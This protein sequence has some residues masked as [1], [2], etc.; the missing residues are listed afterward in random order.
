MGELPVENDR[1]YPSK[2]ENAF[3][4]TVLMT[5]EKESRLLRTRKN[6]YSELRRRKGQT[7][8]VE[9]SLVI[10]HGAALQLHSIERLRA[11]NL[12]SVR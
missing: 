12:G 2:L 6:M 7:D 5:G 8:H 4:D 3:K 11:L 9:S 1:F 10:D